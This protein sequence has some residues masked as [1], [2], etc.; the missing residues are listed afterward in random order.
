[1]SV[2]NLRTMNNY[3]K[4]RA[5]EYRVKKAL[6]ERGYYVIRS[7]GSHSIT[8]LLAFDSK[9][10]IYLIQCKY[11]KAR[12][13]KEEKAKIIET[14]KKFPRLTFLL[15]V[16][17]SGLTFYRLEVKNDRKTKRSLVIKRLNSY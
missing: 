9:C 8:D 11:G 15:A 1:M 3:A 5:F 7:A 10:R 14:L 13:S 2:T 16:N 12:L 17:E 6:E 4:G